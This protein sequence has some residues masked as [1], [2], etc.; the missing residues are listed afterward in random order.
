MAAATVHGTHLTN[1]PEALA[2]LGFACGQYRDTSGVENVLP[3]VQL[4]TVSCY[5]EVFSCSHSSPCAPSSGR[6]IRR[7]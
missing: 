1:V 2:A 7:S 6:S 5:S 3:V 4:D